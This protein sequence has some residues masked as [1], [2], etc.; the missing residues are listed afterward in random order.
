MPNTFVRVQKDIGVANNLA[1]NM[2]NL[3][4]KKMVQFDKHDKIRNPFMVSPNQIAE[5]LRTLQQEE[6]L[7]K[8]SGLLEEEEDLK[9]KLKKKQEELEMLVARQMALIK[10]QPA[11]VGHS[12]DLRLR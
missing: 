6:L 8:K 1:K 10:N 2:Q 12:Q 11:N 4:D 5:R 7:A 3:E 9:Q